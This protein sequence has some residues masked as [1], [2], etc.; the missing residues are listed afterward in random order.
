MEAQR[1]SK[2]IYQLE[3]EREKYAIEASEAAAK[4]MQVSGNRFRSS[5]LA[6]TKTWF[7]LVHAMMRGMSVSGDV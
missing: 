2:Q 4:Y 6:C 5:F 3:K 7:V 1:Q